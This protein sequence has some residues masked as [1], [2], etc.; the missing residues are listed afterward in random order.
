MG[1]G[2]IWPSFWWYGH[3]MLH[4][5]CRGAGPD[6]RALVRMDLRAPSSLG[7]ASAG[8]HPVR[9]RQHRRLYLRVQL[10][11][12]LLWHLRR[13]CPC[14]QRHYEVASGRHA[15]T[16]RGCHVS[17]ADSALGG[18][19]ARAG[20]GG[21]YPNPRGV[22]QVWTSDPQ[23]ESGDPKD[24]DREET[25][26]GKNG[27]EIGGKTKRGC[28]CSSRRREDRVDMRETYGDTRPDD[29]KILRLVV[30]A[31]AKEWMSFSVL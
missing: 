4:L 20:P 15:T 14:W 19:V 27:E 23:E 26:G 13:Q 9:R 28:E 16:G 1:S 6:W 22:L 10:F 31:I 11:G 2:P 21:H 24:A 8:G 25:T 12:A 18:Y 5:H 7:V 29:E 17:R 3:W 30:R